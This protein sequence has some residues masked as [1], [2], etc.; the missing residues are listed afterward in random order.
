[1]GHGMHMELRMFVG[2]IVMC[3]L[4]NVLVHVT[5]DDVAGCFEYYADLAEALDRKQKAPV[6]VPLQTFKSHVLKEPIGVVGLITPWFVVFSFLGIL[7]FVLWLGGI[8]F[9]VA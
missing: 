5:Q 6:S 8:G 7:I 9:I 1:M 4:S 3:I 2:E